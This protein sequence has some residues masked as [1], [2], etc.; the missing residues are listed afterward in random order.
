MPSSVIAG[1]GMDFI[2]DNCAHG[3]EEEET[4]CPSRDQQRFQ[5]FRRGQKDVWGISE[6]L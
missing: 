6:R 5:A 4:V 3:P 2:N 1:E